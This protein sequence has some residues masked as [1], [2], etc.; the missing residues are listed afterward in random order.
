MVAHRRAYLTDYQDAAYAARYRDL[1]ERV[2]AAEQERAKGLGGLAEAVARGYFKL[3]AYKDEYEVARLYAAPAFREHLEQ[4]FEGDYTL[5]FHLAPPLLARRDPNTGEPRKSAYGPWMLKV[6]ERLARYKHLRG[7]WR[8]VFGW[9]AERRME[10]ALIGEYEQTI[11]T[12]LAG[13]CPRN[14]ATAVAVAS[15][16][17]G[18]RGFGHVKRASVEKA[19]AAQ[20]RLMQDFARPAAPPEAA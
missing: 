11:A 17:E 13:L 5:E 19:R 7:T 8:D 10:R 2:R 20:A 12:L 1:V 6:F 15:L 3:L 14:H 18:I 16:A 9:T 4:A